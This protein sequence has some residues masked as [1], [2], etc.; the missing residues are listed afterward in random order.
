MQV[1]RLSKLMKDIDPKP[2]IC[3]EVG[4]V[5]CT[6]IENNMY[7]WRVCGSHQTHCIH[8]WRLAITA[9]VRR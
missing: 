4:L 7:G 3:D 8:V 2:D 5:T 6:S 9:A 1:A